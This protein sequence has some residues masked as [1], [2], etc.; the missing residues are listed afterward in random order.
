MIRMSNCEARENGGNTDRTITI[1][2]NTES[3]ALAQYL[4]NMRQAINNNNNVEKQNN[5]K[6]HLDE[7]LTK[8]VKK[9]NSKF[10][11]NLSTVTLSNDGCTRNIYGY[12]F[13]GNKQQVEVLSWAILVYSVHQQGN[14]TSTYILYIYR[15]DFWIKIKYR[16]QIKCYQK[17]IY[18]NVKKNQIPNS[19]R[20][21]IKIIK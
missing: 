8:Q 11:D 16:Q 6:L 21:N 14:G 12:F 9:I 3:V 5:T 1:T 20:K 17:I 19:L 13:W 7:Q 10:V 18:S 2:G 4:I 15:V